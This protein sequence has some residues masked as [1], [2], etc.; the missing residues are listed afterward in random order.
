MRHRITLILFICLIGM[1]SYGCT[2]TYKVPISQ[3]EHHYSTNFQSIDV[4]NIS[5]IKEKGISSPPLRMPKEKIWESMI[6][7]LMQKAPIV[8]ASR[9][10]GLLVAPP[11][12]IYAEEID[13]VTLY[14]YFIDEMYNQSGKPEQ[15]FIKIDPD[16]KQRYLETT[17]GQ[18]ETQLLA[19]EKLKPNGNWNY[20]FN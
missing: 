2:T 4:P 20:L 3:L 1:F 5:K 6:V 17:L 9:E 11:Y 8:M 18:I 16:D 7:V 15:V 10:S 14:V 12:A 13:G 19:N